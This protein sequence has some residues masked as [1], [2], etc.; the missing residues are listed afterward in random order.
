MVL[1]QKNQKNTKSPQSSKKSIKVVASP[2]EEKTKHGNATSPYF[3]D[4]GVRT[5]VE[6]KKGRQKD[7]GITE[8]IK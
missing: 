7:Q 2:A 6:K 5:P 1:F 3:S 8:I 4:D